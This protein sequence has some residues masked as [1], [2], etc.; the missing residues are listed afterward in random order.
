VW[1]IHRLGTLKINLKRQLSHI[2]TYDCAA[3]QLGQQ[4][5]MLRW[6]LNDCTYSGYCIFIYINKYLENKT[7]F[8]F[9]KYKMNKSDNIL[10][11]KKKCS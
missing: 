7:N 6:H 5:T 10:F 2:S 3:T 4:G 1:P 8:L 9:F 11:N